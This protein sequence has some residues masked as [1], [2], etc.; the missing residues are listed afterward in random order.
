MKRRLLLF[1]I[2]LAFVV[3][4]F[5]APSPV[6]DAPAAPDIVTWNLDG[7]HSEVTFSVTHLTISTVTG[8]FHDFAAD[9]QMDPNDISTLQTSAT[10]Q[11]ASVDTE[12]ERRDDHLRSADFFDAETHPEMRFASTGVSD[13]NSTQFTLNGDLTIKGT[14]RPVSFDAEMR[15]PVVGPQGNPRAAFTATTTISRQDFGLTWN[16]LTE[17]GGVIVGDEVTITLNVQAIQAAS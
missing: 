1:P 10:V 15:G 11:V 9:I 16:R 7:A 17:A 3:A 12:N 4:G 8:K 2:L 13:V 5:S 14:T 6:D